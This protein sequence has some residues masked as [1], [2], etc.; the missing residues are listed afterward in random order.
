MSENYTVMKVL[1][2]DSQKP[3]DDFNQSR[4]VATEIDFYQI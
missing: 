3:F 4:Y 1:I 2:K